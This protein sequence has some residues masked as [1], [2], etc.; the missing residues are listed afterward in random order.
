MSFSPDGQTLATASD[1]NIVIL[2]NFD[3]ANLIARSCDWLRDY[4]ANPTTPPEDKVLC[5]DVLP[6]SQVPVAPIWGA[7]ASHSQIGASQKFQPISTTT[8]LLPQD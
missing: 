1:D 7:L 8:V 2:W 6:L 5:E 3:L 4:V